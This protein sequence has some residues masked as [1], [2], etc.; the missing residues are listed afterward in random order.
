MPKSKKLLRLAAFPMSIPQYLDNCLPYLH[1]FVQT[2]MI[3]EPLS[4]FTNLSRHSSPNC[5]RNISVAT[6]KREIKKSC[7]QKR[8]SNHSK[9]VRKLEEC[10]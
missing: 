4:I 1:S 2:L 8:K 10:F 9:Y 3:S 5:Y 6:Q 7:N